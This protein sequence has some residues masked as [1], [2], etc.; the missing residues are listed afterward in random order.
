MSV[1]TVSWQLS[2]ASRLDL[3]CC[4][5]VVGVV[6]KF[7]RVLLGLISGATMKAVI[8]AS[9]SPLAPT[10]ARLN[11]AQW[12]QSPAVNLC[13]SLSLSENLKNIECFY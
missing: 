9:F 10:I 4:G 3:M 1:L 7:A 2:N 13:R 6:G 12:L 5:D 8:Y 11:V